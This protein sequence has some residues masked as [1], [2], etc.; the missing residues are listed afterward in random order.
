MTERDLQL[1]KNIVKFLSEE[2]DASGATGPQPAENLLA[3]PLPSFRFSSAN[4]AAP[5]EA[6]ASVAAPTSQQLAELEAE[7]AQA[8]AEAAQLRREQQALLHEREGLHEEVESMRQMFAMTYDFMQ[9]GG[10]GETAMADQLGAA[11]ERLFDPQ[12]RLEALFPG[13]LYHATAGQAYLI[14]KFGVVHLVL[15]HNPFTGVQAALFKV[16]VGFAL[17]QVVASRRYVNSSQLVDE[18]L[19]F[20]QLALGVPAQSVE[21]CALIIDA[22]H[23][24][25]EFSG[26]GAPLYV[27]AG[28]Q[29][30]EYPSGPAP[31]GERFAISRPTLRPGAALVC[32]LPADAALPPWV[33]GLGPQPGHWPPVPETW[34]LLVGL[35]L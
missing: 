30:A 12:A 26:T 18:L 31:S 2:P 19:Q 7:L 20:A 28:G 23:A 6:M 27:R 15:A 34:G 3:G 9:Q 14:E 33:Q 4:L 13:S 17:Q 5:A 32:G 1:I 21:A 24:A 25:V 10:A 11:W 16:L 8:R 22:Q 35:C 29:T